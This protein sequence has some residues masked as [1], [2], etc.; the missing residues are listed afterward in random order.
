MSFYRDPFVRLSLG[1]MLNL[2]SFFLGG[3]LIWLAAVSVF[4]VAGREDR[5]TIF[6]FCEAPVMAIGLHFAR[7]RMLRAL[8]RLEEEE[9]REWNR[10]V[11]AP[12]D[13]RHA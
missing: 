3:T 5:V 9:A 8:A 6:A 12:K 1:L 11:N 7:P 4:H 2:G 10:A 13:K